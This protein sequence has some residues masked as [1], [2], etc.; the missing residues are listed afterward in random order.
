MNV[1]WL[2][3]PLAGALSAFT[4]LA[5]LSIGIFVAPLTLAA[6]LAAIRWGGAGEV[7]GLVAGA[8]VTL[9]AI[10]ALNPDWRTTFLP[11]G[12]AL[13][14]GGIGARLIG[15]RKWRTTR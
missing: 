2:L 9:A 6:L 11:A 13:L 5:I 14:L 4:V 12:C 8:G 3:W 15:A 10:G 7:E 1:R